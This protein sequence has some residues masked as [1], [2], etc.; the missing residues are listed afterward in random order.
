MAHFARP[1]ACRRGLFGRLAAFT[2]VELLV[3]IAIIAVLISLLLPA[4]SKA[5]Q[6][7]L[8][9]ACLSNLRQMGLGMAMYANDFKVYPWLGAND[10]YSWNDQIAT[11]LKVLNRTG[12]QYR[13][14]NTDYNYLF[15]VP[16]KYTQRT[17]F[18]CPAA[19][20]TW[21]GGMNPAPSPWFIGSYS[22]NASLV[23][24]YGTTSY[25]VRRPVSSYRNTSNLALIVC[26][27]GVSS[28]ARRVILYGN[29]RG[30]RQDSASLF[31]GENGT[32]LFCDGHADRMF[33]D[34]NVPFIYGWGYLFDRSIAVQPDTKV[35]PL[36]RIVY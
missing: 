9:T 1:I 30:S 28:G 12:G 18:W 19:P 20:E 34:K 8:A 7:A 26:G 5:R 23:F 33:V 29:G 11:Y 2:L 15:K 10:T 6:A 36:P 27:G 21:E 24:V 32:I 14:G 16:F 4:L 17:I 31:H 35:W 3:V 22:Y 25:N 13:I